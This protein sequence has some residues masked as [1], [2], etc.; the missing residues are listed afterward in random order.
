MK[1][2]ERYQEMLRKLLSEIRDECQFTFVAGKVP[3]SVEAALNEP[4]DAKRYTGCSP[5]GV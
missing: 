4:F 1:A 5:R 3:K 2:T